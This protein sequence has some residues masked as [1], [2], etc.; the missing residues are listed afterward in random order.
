MHRFSG[1][2][3]DLDG[4]LSQTNELIFA[5]F[6]YVAKKYIGK[7]FTPDEIIK[8]FGPTEEVTIE[9]LV[10][11][12]YAEKAMNDFYTFYETHHPNMANAYEGIKCVLEL[13][14]KR[15]VLLAIFTGKGKRTT[16]IT[17]DKI[18]IRDYF[19]LIITGDDVTNHKPSADGIRKVMKYFKL[20]PGEILM[21]GDSVADVKAAN[22]AGVPIAAVLWDSYSKEKVMQM[23]VDYRFESVGEF[24]QWLENVY[25]VSG[26]NVID[27]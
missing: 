4:T 12:D 27:R 14:R 16:F 6:N 20:Q 7:T 9:K 18:G 8:L 3:F 10:G 17:L 19:D 15:G 11:N 21:V 13:L 2:I 5:T 22:D 25:T 26:E 23:E 24:S 1:I